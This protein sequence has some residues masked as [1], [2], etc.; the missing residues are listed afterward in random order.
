MLLSAEQATCTTVGRRAYW[1]CENCGKYFSDAATVKAKIPKLK[2]GK[3]YYVRI[4]A[5][6]K[7]GSKKYYSDWSDSLKAKV[8]AE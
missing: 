4:R 6:K 2:P 1:S 8:P 3:T 5:Y 7:V